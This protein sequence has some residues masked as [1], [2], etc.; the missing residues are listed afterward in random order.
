ME[1]NMTEV[2]MEEVELRLSQ[3]GVQSGGHWR[4]EDCK[5]RWKVCVCMCGF[6]LHWEKQ[7]RFYQSSFLLKN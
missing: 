4:P 5:P 7:I 2:P 3:L 6:L 1:V